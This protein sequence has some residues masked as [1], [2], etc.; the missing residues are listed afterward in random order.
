TFTAHPNPSLTPQGKLRD[1]IAY[2]K[3]NRYDFVRLQPWVAYEERGAFYSRFGAA[4]LT[5]PQSIETDLAVRIRVF[6]YLWAGLPIVTSSAPGTDEL[7]TTYGAGVVV[8]S[9]S[10]ADFAAA[11]VHALRDRHMR[12]GARRFVDDH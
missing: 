12:D 2:I 4:L 11:L 10:A 8:P 7:L 3:R 5:F 9:T 6:D 1:A